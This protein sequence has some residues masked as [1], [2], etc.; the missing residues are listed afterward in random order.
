MEITVQKQSVQRRKRPEKEERGGG[1]MK[2]NFGLE[3]SGGGG[4]AHI[5]NPLWGGI[6]PSTAARSEHVGVERG[7]ARTPKPGG[8][9]HTMGQP[10]DNPTKRETMEMKWREGK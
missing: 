8:S 2:S 7:Q 5:T 3:L 4:I 6:E 1:V 10:T 9:P